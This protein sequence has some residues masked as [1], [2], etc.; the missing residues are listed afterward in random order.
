ML[1]SLTT[2]TPTMRSALRNLVADIA[3]H[4][5]VSPINE[6]A[7]LGIDGEREAEFYFMGSRTDPHGFVVCDERDGTLM[8]GVHP[9][10]RGQ[11]FGTQLLEEALRSHPDSAVWAFGTL[12]GAE[13]LAAR[14][15]LTP[16]RQLLRMER[17]LDPPS[18]VSVPEGFEIVAYT[19]DD[20]EAVV[21]I[22]AA[23]F[24]HH[25]EQGRLSV[26]EFLKLT[27]QPW[28]DPAGLLIAK[29]NGVAVGFHWTK[30]HGQGLGEVYVLAVSPDHEGRGLGRVLLAEG[31]NHLARQGDQRVQLYVE[32]AESRV[33]NMY[34]VAG[35]SVAQT[36]TSYRVDR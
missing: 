32:A 22:N 19:P 16:V 2:L 27:R 5:G 30:R 35:F 36:D 25:P 24:A 18:Q 11:G 6:S 3:T 10:H 29:S 14:V 20:A 9:D 26:G 28:F 13:S 33:V 7:S 8:V 1:V 15:G 23:A 31:L 21:S 12:P 4:D 34:K 17:P